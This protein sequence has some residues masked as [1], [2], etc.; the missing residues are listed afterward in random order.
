MTSID[1]SDDAAS[2]RHRRS[3]GTAAAEPGRLVG[4]LLSVRVVPPM[5]PSIEGFASAPA[6]SNLSSRWRE[7]QHCDASTV[8]KARRHRTGK[9]EV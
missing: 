2:R 3:V 6:R 1:T 8:H 9:G 5:S 4:V 7:R